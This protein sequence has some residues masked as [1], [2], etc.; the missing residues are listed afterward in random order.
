M[1]TC[2]N[3]ILPAHMEEWLRKLQKNVQNAPSGSAP[4]EE[5]LDF[6]RTQ[7]RLLD[8]SV[9]VLDGNV[10]F[11]GCA[12]PEKDKSKEGIHEISP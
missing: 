5:K 3:V 8:L 12:H 4:K 7:Y 1:E 6:I 10:Y 11:V 9:R 2:N